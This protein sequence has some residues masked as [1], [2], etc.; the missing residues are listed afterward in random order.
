MKETKKV[1]EN[2]R[3]IE[4][5]AEINQEG[6]T[7]TDEKQKKPVCDKDVGFESGTRETER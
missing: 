7:E 5:K 3:G 2:V 1:K 6:R 4:K